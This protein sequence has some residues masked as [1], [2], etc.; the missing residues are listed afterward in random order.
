LAAHT[1]GRDDAV[2]GHLEAALGVSRRIG[3]QPF[4]AL[5][6]VELGAA[7]A[8]RGA[9]GSDT[10][11]AEG[12]AG[13]AALGLSGRG[14]RAAARL[15]APVAGAAPAAPA[16]PEP[17]PTRSTVEVG[18]L[19]FAG[20][21]WE[22]AAGDERAVLPDAV[23]MRYLAR[24]LAAP[25]REI[26][27]DELAGLGVAAARQ[28]TLDATAIS[29]YRAR[30][31]DLQEQLDRADAAGDVDRSERART[32]LDQ[33]LEHV[34][35]ELGLGGRARSF[36]DERERARTAV[37][38]AIRRVLDRIAASAPDLGGALLQSVRTGSVCCYQPVDGLP[39]RWDTA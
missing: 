36:A 22:I 25:G 15:G 31:R 12:R 29:A 17:A 34:G 32:E 9:A 7:L 6:R 35:A 39:D 2:V 23:G 37:Q 3:N 18:V 24:L 8:A 30:I 28:P 4:L 19:R 27:A 11:L 1:A 10:M 14:E 20:G 5:G 26:G 33:L 16:T 38:K 21:S 13:L